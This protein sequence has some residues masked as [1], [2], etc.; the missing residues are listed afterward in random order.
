M[1]TS[2]SIDFT[3]NRDEIILDAAEEIG[4]AVDGEALDPSFVGVASRVLNR[5]TKAWMGH[6]LQL[7]KRDEQSVTLVASTNTYTLGPTGS[8]ASSTRPLRIIELDRKDSN[9]ITTGLTKMSLEEYDSLTN[10]STNGTPVNYFY[11]PS[12]PDGTLKVWPTPDATVAAEF[13]LEIT[14]QSPI[15][16][17][18]NNIDDA[19]FPVEWLEALVYGL[20]R[21]LASKYG[22]LEPYELEDLKQQAQEA[23]DLAMSWDTEDDS[24]YFQPDVDR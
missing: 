17:F 23:L 13:T 24:V 3:M 15:E 19:D 9:N 10:K 22:S 21:R 7:W 8:V 6:G 4:I 5:M 18:D 14:Y 12:L 1:A 20:A 16:D 11:N 2:G